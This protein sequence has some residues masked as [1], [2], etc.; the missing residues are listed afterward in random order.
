MQSPLNL[1]P[2]SKQMPSLLM[3][4]L[5]FLAMHSQFSMHRWPDSTSLA[6]PDRKSHCLDISVPYHM[7]TSTGPASASIQTDPGLLIWFLS[8]FLWLAMV[9][10]GTC[11][12]RNNSNRQQLGFNP[13]SIYNVMILTVHFRDF[14]QCC[15]RQPYSES[16]FP[17]KE[18]DLSY[19]HGCQETGS[20]S[21]LSL[22][23][24]FVSLFTSLFFDFISETGVV[25]L[26]F[27]VASH[28]KTLHGI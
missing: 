19:S 12:T 17:D 14:S 24:D 27:S 16:F 3:Q 2:P 10:K 23:S 5:P 7:L 6:H 22:L 26:A 18:T 25:I 4:Y 15:C 9:K 20:Y 28:L 13:F 1:L 21:K 8:F 11:N